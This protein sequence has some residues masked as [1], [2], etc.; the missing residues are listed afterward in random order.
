MKIDVLAI[1][2]LLAD[3]ISHDYINTLS[4]TNNFQ[5]F[6]G[7]SPANLSAN[8]KWLG[9]NAELVACVGNDGIGKFLT[10]EI[11]KIGLSTKYISLNNDYPTSLVLVGKSKGT[12]DFIAYRMADTQLPS[13]DEK[14]LLN[15][16]IIHT[17]AF[18]LSK[19]PARINILQALKHAANHGGIISV[20]WNFAQQIWGSDK[21]I[22][23]F[24]FICTLN[25]LLK[26]S[27]DDF[28][29]FLNNP[30][31]NEEDAKA[32][33]NTIKTQ[34][35]CLTCG[36]NGVWYKFKDEWKFKSSLSVTE[37]VDTTGAGDAFW[38]AFL[39]SYVSDN[40]IETAIDFALE[41]AAKKIQKLGP[42]YLQ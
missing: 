9:K 16:K 17:S 7:G 38:A 40:Q 23:T 1:G 32:F 20:D 36:A 30:N 26:I 13:I 19:N 11:Y 25:P 4:E 3:L 41:I 18:A 27:L 33:L 10:N 8:V 5:M 12:P 24:N 14:L 34:F 42:L 29:R 28:Q 21:G 37:V 2:E 39:S 22:S 15:A 31:A 6:Q 35:I